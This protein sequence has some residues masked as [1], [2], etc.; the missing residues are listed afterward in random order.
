MQKMSWMV[1][2]VFQR[3]LDNMGYLHLSITELHELLKKG[4]VTPL[5]L[6]KEAIDKMKADNNNAFEYIME[7]EALEQASLLTKC[8]EDNPLWGIPF[9]I[10]DNYSTKD[11]PTCGSSDILKGYVPIFSSEVYQRLINKH[12]IPVAK[13]TLDE[14]A[15]GGSG[16]TG[17]LGKTYNPWDKSHK[18]Q[19]GGS[20]CGSAAMVSAGIVPFSIGSDTGDS[21]R[22]PASYNAL[23]GFKPSWGRISRFGLFPFATSLDHV[24]YFTR[25]VEDSA[26]LLNVL[27]GRDD[28]DSSSSFKEVED[29]TLNLNKDVKGKKLAVIKEIV[30]SIDNKDIINAFNSSVEKLRASGVIIDYVH[31][32]LSLLKA[33]YPAYIVISCAEATSNNANLDG[34][35]FGQREDGDTYQEVIMKTRTNGFSELIRRRFIIGSYS[36]LKENQNELFLR[37]QKARRLIVNATNDILKEYD[38]IYCPASP[39]VAPLFVGSSDKLSNEYLIADNYLAIG[40]FAGLPSITIPLGFSEKLPFGV[41]LTCKAFE[42]SNTFN[43]ASKIEEVIGIKNIIAKEG[44]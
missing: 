14:L 21:V 8:E 23:V 10:K 28:K 5:D 37:A 6:V 41:N 30:D 2:S 36:L 25:N 18:H 13:T 27:A 34:I 19:V 9:G 17:H 3:W 16:T 31:M 32:D 40:N 11:V 29:Y 15:M 1:K 12:A 22:K 24:A 39:S 33:I 38:G 35:K 7:K 26:I 43:L 20:S 42:E 4:E 44:E